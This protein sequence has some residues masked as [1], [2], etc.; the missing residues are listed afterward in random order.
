[1]VCLS[2]WLREACSYDPVC[3][4]WA[5]A[6]VQHRC[7]LGNNLTLDYPSPRKGPSRRQRDLQLHK[8]WNAVLIMAAE[9]VQT[10]SLLITW[11]CLVQIQPPRVLEPNVLTGFAIRCNPS[12]GNEM[13]DQCPATDYKCPVLRFGVC[14]NGFPALNPKP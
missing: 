11:T 12:H 13:D 7:F 14:N 6:D 3:V 10:S 8:D 4:E 9:D 2:S 1:M 5:I